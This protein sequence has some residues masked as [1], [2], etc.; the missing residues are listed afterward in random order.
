MSTRRLDRVVTNA[1]T[2]P[3][4]PHSP[5]TV[6]K[7]PPSIVKRERPLDGR[8]IGVSRIDAERRSPGRLRAQSTRPFVVC[9]ARRP[10][11]S[12]TTGP[13]PVQN[14]VR[15]LQQVER[16]SRLVQLVEPP[17]T[18]LRHDHGLERRRR[19]QEDRRAGQGDR[20]PGLCA[21]LEEERREVERVHD[22]GRLELVEAA[23]TIGIAE[24]RS[25]RSE[26]N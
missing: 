6:S 25:T 23:Q 21:P 17:S 16:R 2:S 22:V 8:P 13:C 26:T 19:R 10:G 4:M 11:G 1:A 24:A 9:S 5:R 12:P 20:H 14:R 7:S 18:E 3:R 15:P